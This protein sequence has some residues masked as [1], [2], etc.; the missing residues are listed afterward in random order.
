MK[1]AY[2]RNIFENI[3]SNFDWLFQRINDA[4]LHV[5]PRSFIDLATTEGKQTIVMRDGTLLSA[6]KVHGSTRDIR[7]EEYVEMFSTLENTFKS[8]FLSKDHYF[9]WTFKSD[10]EN[11]DSAIAN[12]WTNQAIE[13]AEKLELDMKDIIKEIHDVYADK[14]QEESVYLLVWTNIHMTTKQEKSLHTERQNDFMKG[15]PRHSEAQPIKF[16]APDFY[17]KHIATCEQL[18]SELLNVSIYANVADT[19]EFLR[20]LRINIDETFTSKNWSPRVPGDPIPLSIL[21]D[22]SLIHI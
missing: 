10:P 14:C 9:S 15:V 1:Q 16:T 19:H 21:S 5:N 17:E 2:N 6:I 8:F 4:F 20:D 7:Y 22:L 3:T 13:V 12:A 11:V 18:V